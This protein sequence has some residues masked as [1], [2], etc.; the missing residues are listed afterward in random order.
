LD[1]TVRFVDQSPFSNESEDSSTILIHVLVDGFTANGTVWYRGQEIEFTPN[2]PAY[3]ATVNRYGESWLDFDARKQM[4]RWK[5]VMFAHGPW[6]GADYEDEKAAEAE[7]KRARAAPE[8]S[9][10]GV[11]RT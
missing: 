9:P 5:N 1:S 10:V 3:E 8:L 6:P 11:R 2:T 4:R 7:R